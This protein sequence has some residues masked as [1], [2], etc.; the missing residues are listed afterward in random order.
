MTKI[1]QNLVTFSFPSA[2]IF[3]MLYCFGFFTTRFTY[4]YPYF[5][6]SNL[7]TKHNRRFNRANFTYFCFH[8][9]NIIESNYFASLSFKSFNETYSNALLFVASN[10]T[11][12]A[13]PACSASFHLKAHKHQMFPAFNPGK[14]VAG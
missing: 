5:S 2:T 3:V 6:S 13:T 1:K 12:G 10:T 7:N 9:I 4:K 11:G 8:C 14:P